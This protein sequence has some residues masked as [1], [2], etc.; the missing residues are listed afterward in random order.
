MSEPVCSKLNYYM[1]GYHQKFGVK[2]ILP[3]NY[4]FS[5]INQTFDVDF[6]DERAE[7][8]IQGEFFQLVWN[9]FPKLHYLFW[10]TPNGGLR[11]KFEAARFKAM[12]VVS[13]VPDI[14]LTGG[15]TP[16]CYL[17]FKDLKGKQGVN[18]KAFQ[19]AANASFFDYHI[20]R[21]VGTALKIFVEFYDVFE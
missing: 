18:Q 3:S 2:W 10:H 5:K 15:I 17:E 21:N 20:C 4:D 14:I 9:N 7:D 6:K 13:G 11:N 19:I 12:G 1:N 16:I 8:V